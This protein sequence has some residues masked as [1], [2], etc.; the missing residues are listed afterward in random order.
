[1]GVH[2]WWASPA[3]ATP[4]LLARLDDAERSR[5]DAFRLAVDRDRFVVGA[6]LVR[7][8][9]STLSGVP[10]SQVSIDRSCDRCGRPHGRVRTSDAE[11]HL[12][13]SH[14]GGAVVVA[15]GDVPLGIDV[16]PVDP[17]QDLTTVAATA[18]TATELAPLASLDEPDF[19]RRF[20]QHWVAKEAVLK[21]SGDGLRLPMQGIELAGAEPPLRLVTWRERPKLAP[22]VTLHAL[23][24]APAGHEAAIA[25][26]GGSAHEPIVEARPLA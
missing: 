12:S 4:A 8:L 6:A 2:V 10:P 7:G 17:A 24:G 16:E 1:M 5:A 18:L 14:A 13:V 11:V 21:A 26:V 9:V 22:A 15:A 19:N 20:L 3:D 23:Y 25:L